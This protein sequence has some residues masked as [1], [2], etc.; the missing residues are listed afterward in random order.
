MPLEFRGVS[1]PP[2]H[3]LTVSAPSGAVIGILGEDGAG[4]RAL[5]RLAAG[6]EQPVAGQVVCAG[7]RRYVG[8]MDSLEFSSAGLL[9]IEHS[10]ALLDTLKRAQAAV[11]IGRLRDSGATVLIVSHELELLQSLCD[12]VWWLES[13][14]LIRRGDPREV[15]DS[16]RKQV[17]QKFRAW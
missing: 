4:Q 5:L 7:E 2:L 8:F 11:E 9:A 12:E 1:F 13:G 15:L 14:S 16:Y 6:I 10:L 17:A 3:D